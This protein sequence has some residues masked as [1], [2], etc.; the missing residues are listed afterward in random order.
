MSDLQ[1]AVP[2]LAAAYDLIDETTGQVPGAALEI[3]TA[4]LA[5]VDANDEGAE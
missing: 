4:V 1:C 3:F 5:A 2:A